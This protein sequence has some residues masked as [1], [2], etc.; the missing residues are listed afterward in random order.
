[1]STLQ[2][3]AEIAGYRIESLIGRGGMAVVY[4][5]EDTRLGRKVA[6]K[7][8][9]P[10][11]AD[12]EQFRHRFI[13]ESR[14]AAS[15]DHPNIVPIYEAGEADGQLFIAMRYVI[16]SDLKAV[17]LEQGG[18]LPAAWT[19]RLFSQ[20][21]D[22]LDSAHRAGLVHRDVKPGNILVAS[23]GRPRAALGDHVYLTDFGLTKRTSE[24]SGALTGT[25]RFLGTVDYV[26]PEQI[27]GRPV[28]P[29]T[30]IYALGCVLY[31][32]LT[33]HLPFRR[34]DDAAL[35]WAHLVETPPRI[36]AIRPELSSA[37]DEVVA[38]AMAKEPGDRYE[39]GEEMLR[40]L[41]PALERPGLGAP[42]PGGPVIDGPVI[43]GPVIDG[44]VIGEAV[45]DETVPHGSAGAPT[46]A[47]TTTGVPEPAVRASR[48][49][50]A[51]YSLA[52]DLG[53]S[54]VAAAVADDH[55]LEMFS[56]GDGSLVEPAAVY[57]HH[58]GR[59]LTGDAAARRAVSHPDRYA[60]EVKRSLGNPTPVV[61]G[62]APYAVGDLLGTLLRDVLVRVAER[63]GAEPEVVALTHPATWGPLRRQLFEDVAAAAALPDPLYTSEPEAAAAHYAST[64]PLEEGAVL[65]VYDLGG[66]TF[67]ATVLRRTARGFEILGTPEGI[68]RLGGADFD[69]AVFTHVT[70]LAGGALSHLDLSDMRT[71]VALARLRQD[72]TLAK[73]ALSVDT[74]ATIPVFLPNRHF[75]VTL[76]RSDLESMIRAPLESTIGTLDRVV[77]V[78]GLDPAGLTAVLLV[79]G[80]SRIPLVAEMVAEAFGRPIVVGAHP[81]HAVALGAVLLAEARRTNA[82][83]A[84]P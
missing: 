1:M 26:A 79:G 23:G 41:Q 9:P 4:R 55:R 61:L 15:L 48:V 57:V 7:L 44:P 2:P 29:A 35:L 18:R 60:R 10:Q 25:G 21:G 62:G 81:K 63:E 52:V 28:G 65:A 3:G 13:R 43:D 38:R 83:T 82:P 78:A 34:D 37:V 68:E 27:Q 54:F 84:V 47:D 58:D 45:I 22:A 42:A 33:G 69:D 12:S 74:E 49:G 76:T 14:L 66:G 16:G 50:P 11:L 32:C 64:R 6:L 46:T 39:S 71:V 8:L 80:S 59:L 70:Y 30:D 36:T 53:T 5:A 31:E 72:C 40:E 75:E 19:V 17:L 24:L 73:E 20:L 56:L 51:A 67:D 77:R